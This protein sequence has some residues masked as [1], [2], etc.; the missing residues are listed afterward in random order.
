MK[1]SSFLVALLATRYKKTQGKLPL[2]KSVSCCDQYYA[3][4]GI[5]DSQE[6]L[7]VTSS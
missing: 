7:N 3:R 4:H 6:R 2:S 1:K 5:L